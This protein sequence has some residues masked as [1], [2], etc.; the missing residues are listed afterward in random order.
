MEEERIE[1]HKEFQQAKSDDEG[2]IALLEKTV[3]VLSAY[4]KKN[5][6]EMGPIQGSVKLMQEPEFEV[7]QWQ[8]PDATFSD[9]GKRKNQSKGIIQI[10]TMLKE[11]LEDEI[12]NGIKDEV[13]SQAEFEK[14]VATAKALIADLTE[15]KT[16][17]ENTRAETDEQRELEHS[18]MKDNKGSLVDKQEY[19]KSITEGCDWL[20]KSFDE[21]VMKRK[22]EM[23]GLV[24]AKEYLA[25]AAP[26]S[27]MLETSQT[28]DDSKLSDISFHGMSFLQRN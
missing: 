1:E 26:P 25:G 27:A 28:F 24:K 15:K 8:A 2:A 14:A 21:R 4:Y 6:I 20:L 9:K 17:L 22:A 3:E 16:N 19:R 23:E 10:L 5:K 13:A 7:S 11:D 12:K 18:T